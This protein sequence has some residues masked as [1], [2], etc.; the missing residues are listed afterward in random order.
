MNKW[1]QGN[2][3]N[4]LLRATNWVGDA[5]LT[6][7][8]IRAVRENFPDAAVTILAKPWVAPVFFDNPNI[9]RILSYDG[10]GAHKGA[11]GKLKLSRALRRLDFD[12]AILLQNAFEAALITWLAGIP[13]RVGY[14]TDGRGLLLTHP[15]P[16]STHH[17][18]IHETQ[19]YLGIL[20]EVGLHAADG[21]LTL[22]LNDAERTAAREM[23]QTLGIVDPGDK[24]VGI[25][26][27]ATYGSAK[28][29]LPERFA[30]LCDR[31]HDSHGVQT[32]VFGGPKEQAVGETVCRLMGK[33]AANL[34]GRT[35]LRLA[36]ALIEQCH[37]FITNDSGL[38][39][40]A[41]AL[42]VPV[43]AIFG[44]TNPGT[45]GPLGR[46]SHVIRVPVACSPCLKQ[47]CPTD[48]RCMTE[49]TVDRVYET[50]ADILERKGR[51]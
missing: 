32:L 24:I 51:V 8:A 11:L 50:A 47:E 9:D 1:V 27:G 33:R 35:D 12:L 44:S 2:I 39:H 42:K 43:V 17:K 23:L 46:H 40:V 26:P 3:H 48:H 6:T 10:N 36:S 29:W 45:T 14:N 30:A 49:V 20:R 41:A 25:G 38:M 16:V 31:L 5:I 37:L 22:N 15:V 4:I 13:R 21:A 7:P 18:Q 19:Y 28:R 34:C